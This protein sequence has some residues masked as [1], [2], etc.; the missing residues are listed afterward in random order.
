[1]GLVPRLVPTFGDGPQI[2]PIALNTCLC[3][4][5]HMVPNDQH[6]E[7]NL[8]AEVHIACLG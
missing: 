5:A 6:L 2:L 4:S 8:N 1:M 7:K 3:T